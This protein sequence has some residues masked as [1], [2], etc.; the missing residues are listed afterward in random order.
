MTYRLCSSLDQTRISS[1]STLK[2]KI[3]VWRAE[4]VLPPGRSFNQYQGLAKAVLAIRQNPACMPTD[5]KIVEAVQDRFKITARTVKRIRI[6][7]GLRRC[8]RAVN[9]DIPENL[10][11]AVILRLVDPMQR[12]KDDQLAEEMNSKA[13]MLARRRY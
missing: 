10:I 12:P 9:F 7:N 4:E 2:R 5:E 3:K 8:E 11:A 1:D 6:S 13:S